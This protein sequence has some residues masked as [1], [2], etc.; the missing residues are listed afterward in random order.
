VP[1]KG[2]ILT[3]IIRH[4]DNAA[5]LH[6]HQQQILQLCM[7]LLSN[8]THNLLPAELPCALF[9]PR[10]RCND[11]ALT[12]MMHTP[13]SY[14]P[15]R[16][17]LA[18]AVARASVYV[19]CSGAQTSC[20]I[21]ITPEAP[22]AKRPAPGYR[23]RLPRRKAHLRVTTWDL[24]VGK[25][26]LQLSLASDRPIGPAS[27]YVQSKPAWTSLYGSKLLYSHQAAAWACRQWVTLHNCLA[28]W[29]GCQHWR[30]QRAEQP[31]V[32]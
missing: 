6:S 18:A 26:W 27:I 15:P 13:L 5:S 7:Q 1:D 23:P 32:A 20:C 11:A 12:A 24:Q 31:G 21:H 4:Y 22:Y 17:Q 28:K 9:A 25:K 3:C 16:R 2:L 8:V 29:S 10:V 14:L 19:M 30:V